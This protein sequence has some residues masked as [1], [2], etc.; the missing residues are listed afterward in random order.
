MSD[1]IL[2]IAAHPDDEILGCG[3]TLY[4]HHIK[5]DKIFAVYMTSGEEARTEV[6][7]RTIK[8]R[9]SALLNIVDYLAIEE[10][11]EFDLP[12][13]KLDTVPLL[14]IIQ[15]IEAVIGITKPKVIYTHHIGDL[16]IDHRITAEAV[17]TATRPF[18]YN[19]IETILGF[20]VLSSTE[21][22][23]K[24]SDIFFPNYFVDVT[25][26][27]DNKIEML[28]FYAK[29]MRSF[30]HP[31]SNEGVTVLAKMRGLQAGLKAAEAFQI[32]RHVKR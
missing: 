19:M 6:T 29:E 1:H 13:N 2:V 24:S 7:P 30:P 3:A 16:N 20:E 21:L 28:S 15:K 27:L 14:D 31:R 9:R 25:E 5:G 26:E 22:A 11:W 23:I 4:R 32:L 12:D 18:V 8:Q 10:F 17:R